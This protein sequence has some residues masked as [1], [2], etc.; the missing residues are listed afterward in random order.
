MYLGSF[1]HC[2]KSLV[3]TY[4]KPAS[5]IWRKKDPRK[6]RTRVAHPSPALALLR[7]AVTSMIPSIHPE[8]HRA[9]KTNYTQILFGPS[10][11]QCENICMDTR[12]HTSTCTCA[13]QL[14]TEHGNEE[15]RQGELSKSFQITSLTSGWS[16]CKNFISGMGGLLFGALMAIEDT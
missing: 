14:K 3:S 8:W 10:T 16:R 2:V 9:W 5:G 4:A 7:V 13:S 12:T 11:L 15:S 1:L 6:P